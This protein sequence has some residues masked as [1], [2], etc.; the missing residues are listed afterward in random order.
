MNSLLSRIFRSRARAEHLTFTVYTRAQ[1]CCCHKAL[2]LLRDYQRRHGFQIA[3]VDVDADP[4]LVAKYNTEV[5]VVEV[6]GKVRFRGVVN[7]T[8]LVR[9][10]E[11]AS[12]GAED[13]RSQQRINLSDDG[14][15]KEA[16]FSVEGDPT[17]SRPVDGM[18]VRQALRLLVL[19]IMLELPLREAGYGTIAFGLLMI[20]VSY[21]A[22]C[23]AGDTRILRRIYLAVVAPLILIDLCIV[24]LGSGDVL[25]AVAGVVP[26]GAPRASRPWRSSS[27]S[28]AR[29][30]VSLDTI[31]GGVCV[32]LLI[33]ETF[34]FLFGM[35][36]LTRGG[37]YPRGGTTC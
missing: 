15:Q 26:G 19:S 36:E 35:T 1:C 10:L 29:E 33:G 17:V 3:E 20:S 31:L 8:L 37:S 16:G 32:Y 6:N 18:A 7:P 2:D 24:T 13:P 23:A 34:A 27:T 25:A 14:Y 22:A 9:L 12:P 21:A 30:R 28:C 5:P 11:A 4:A